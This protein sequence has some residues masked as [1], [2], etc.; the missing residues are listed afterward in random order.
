MSEESNLQSKTKLSKKPI[1]I[2]V[3]VLAVVVIAALSLT[4]VEFYN[5]SRGLCRTQKDVEHYAAL[6]NSLCILAGVFEGREAEIAAERMI[7]DEDVVPASLSMRCFFYDALIAV[8]KEKY[9]PYILSH[10]E[11]TYRPM[12]ELGN[13]TVWETDLGES[14]FDNAGSLCHGWSAIPVY[15]YNLLK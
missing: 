3:I 14:D 10:I 7:S 9:T 11:K 13:G 6:T 2:T 5:R 8:D 4:R 12:I 15:Y 1:I